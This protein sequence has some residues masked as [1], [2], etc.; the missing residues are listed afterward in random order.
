MEDFTHVQSFICVGTMSWC[1]CVL[2]QH[3]LGACCEAIRKRDVDGDLFLVST[4]LFC[5]DYWTSGSV[6]TFV[7]FCTNQVPV[8]VTKSHGQGL[9]KGSWRPRLTR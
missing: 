4:E 6:F 1:V 2:F 3:G 5:F 9:I 7:L 8:P